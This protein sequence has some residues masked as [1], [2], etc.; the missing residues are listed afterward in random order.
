MA[1][2]LESGENKDKLEKKPSV[3]A[4]SQQCHLSKESS[5]RSEGSMSSYFGSTE[6][7]FITQLFVFISEM[8]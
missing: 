3:P 8:H 5:A 1:I 4:H 2:L 7:W 6:A